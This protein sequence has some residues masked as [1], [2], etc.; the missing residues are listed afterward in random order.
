[1]PPLHSDG[2][3]PDQVFE[4]QEHLYRRVWP[5]HVISENELNPASIS[6]RDDDPSVVRSKY[7]TP[8]DA[9]HTDCADDQDV[10]SFE[11]YAVSASAV[12]LS[13][14]C[15]DTRRVFVFRPVHAPLSACYAH[16]LISCRE[17]ARNP[18]QHVE[19]TRPVR[20]D[21]RAKFAAAMSK[22]DLSN[23]ENSE[24]ETAPV[25]TAVGGL[26]ALEANAVSQSVGWWKR[27]CRIFRRK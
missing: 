26:N 23:V 13:L 25:P 18:D 1:L 14:L 6:F 7:G 11:V 3:F 10:S 20:N 9:L 4:P 8:S 17:P 15:P 12:E 22:C 24:D 2:R 16:S 21:F 5:A 19:P 27:L